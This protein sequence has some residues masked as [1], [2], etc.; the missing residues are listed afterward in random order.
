MRT[1]SIHRAQG[2]ALTP[3]GPK[4]VTIIIEAQIPDDHGPDIWTNDAIAIAK[5]LRATLPGGTWDRLVAEMLR[6]HASNL[7]ITRPQR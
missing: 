7:I 5:T 1:L 2:H 6:L 3:D 4:P